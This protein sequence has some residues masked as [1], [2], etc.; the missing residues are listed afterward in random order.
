[1]LLINHGFSSRKIHIRPH[2]IYWINWPSISDNVIQTRLEKLFLHEGNFLVLSVHSTKNFSSLKLKILVFNWRA[3]KHAD[4]LKGRLWEV[5][6]GLRLYSLVSQTSRQ[7]YGPVIK[8]L[9][10]GRPSKKKLR[11]FGHMSN[12][13]HPSYLVPWYGH[14]KV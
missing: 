4:R 8:N 14:K 1:M 2:W 11:I 13:C 3:G 12:L 6:G 7:E 9:H 5:S 10:L